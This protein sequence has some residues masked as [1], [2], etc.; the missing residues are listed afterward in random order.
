MWG[1]YNYATN[2]RYSE[3]KEC[4]SAETAEV[5]CWP[6]NGALTDIWDH[7]DTVKGNLTVTEVLE[8][9]NTVAAFPA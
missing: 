5:A 4:Q 2:Q 7:G 9:L 3:G 1:T 6:E 8:F